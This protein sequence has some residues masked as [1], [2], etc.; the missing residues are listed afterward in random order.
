M[1]APTKA[2]QNFTFLYP[3][4]KDAIIKD[5]KLEP[6]SVL[7]PPSPNIEPIPPKISYFL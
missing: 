7:I 4:G 1:G 6:Q 3:R 2:L 5:L